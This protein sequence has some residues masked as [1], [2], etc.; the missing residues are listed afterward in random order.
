[1]HA[2]GGYVPVR[3]SLHTLRTGKY[4][5]IQQ[6]LDI[7][8]YIDSVGTIRVLWRSSR[9]YRR[10]HTETFHEVCHNNNNNNIVA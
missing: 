10:T 3:L 9:L 6:Y 4:N 7:F 2:N 1:M 8:V 5:S